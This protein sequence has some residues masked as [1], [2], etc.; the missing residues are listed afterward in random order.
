MVATSGWQMHS[1]LP[2]S[3][4]SMYF[5]SIRRYESGA[6]TVQIMRSVK[7]TSGFSSTNRAVYP[8]GDQLAGTMA[9]LLLLLL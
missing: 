8:V 1:R 5:R 6:V 3:Q 7:E 2:S 4:T 9:V